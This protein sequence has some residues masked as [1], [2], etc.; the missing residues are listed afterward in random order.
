MQK[1]QNK[2]KT[3]IKIIYITPT[4]R[5]GGAERF[6]VDLI[7]NLDKNKYLPTLILFQEA[8]LWIKELKDAHI[9]VIVL[10]KRFK[11]D[12]INF[13][14]ILKNIK[15][16][17]PDIVHTQLGGDIYGRLA[18]KILKIPIIISTEQNLNPDE[19]IIRNL[20][21]RF[22]NKFASKIIAITLAVKNDLMKRYNVPDNKIEIISNGVNI[23]KFF[24]LNKNTIKKTKEIVIGT[25]GRLVPQKGHNIL[26]EALAK[27]N[28]LNFKCFIAG[29]GPLKNQLKNQINS[30]G[31]QNK[32]KL[33]G[34]IDDVPNFLNSL[35]VFV[36][37]S[38]WEGQGIVIMEAALKGLP[39]I[40]SEVDGIKELLNQDTAYLVKPG[41]PEELASKISYVFKN[42]N[43]EEIKIKTIKLK[44]EAIDKYSIKKIT[45]N[46]EELYQ[47]IL[48]SK[49]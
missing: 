20:F 1:N 31:L 42:I 10:R 47:K 37:P 21:K 49:N 39:I 40:A 48:H 11:I 43:S 18:A 38:I 15:K 22:T 8:G 6:I 46:Y 13:L 2:Q 19:N 23:N 3:K 4:L 28:N 35:D 17:R 33:V 24:K 30:F 34:L 14:T 12:I 32:I 44:Q 41:S 5:Q 7:L 45:E 16:N 26:I 25:I 9:N 36:F 27:I 29:D